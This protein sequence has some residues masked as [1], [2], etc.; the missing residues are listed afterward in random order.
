[1]IS[2]PQ[3]RVNAGMSQADLAEE[4]GVSAETVRK[5]ENGHR[6]TARV[7]KKFADYFEVEYTDLWPIEEPT[8]V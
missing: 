2:I 1:M 4:I 3:H 5:V 7:G 8:N 6:P